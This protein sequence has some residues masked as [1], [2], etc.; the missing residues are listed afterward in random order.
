MLSEKQT[1]TECN[2][3]NFQ[4]WKTDQRNVHGQKEL[5][6]SKGGREARRGGGD[7]TREGRKEGE[8]ESEFVGFQKM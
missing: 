8:R 3:L 1:E 7:E 6:R 2:A 4:S 5:E